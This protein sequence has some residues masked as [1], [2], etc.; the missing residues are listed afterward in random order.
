M[1][2][3]DSQL[4]LTLQTHRLRT[5]YGVAKI[6]VEAGSAETIMARALA[7]MGRELNWDYCICWR[8]DSEGDRA[9]MRVVATWL[10][11]PS[12]YADLTQHAQELRV[13]PGV[14]V[15][16]RAWSLGATLWLEDMAREPDFLGS[17]VARA[18][19]LGAG[20]CCPI[21]IRG[22][23]INPPALRQPVKN[24]AEGLQYR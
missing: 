14:G 17:D 12:L 4:E 20:V 1:I 10:R 5:E 11:D 7:V 2:E 19:G 9:M 13:T 8:V 18:A 3:P 16:G 21:V 22:E 6:L 15:V 23:I 24:P